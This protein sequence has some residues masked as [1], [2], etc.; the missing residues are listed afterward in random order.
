MTEYRATTRSQAETEALAQSLAGAL[1]PGAFLALYGEL[2]AGKTAFARGVA[3]GLGIQ[4]ITSPTFT[5]VQEYEGCAE[6][7]PLFHF[8]AYRLSG[9]EELDAIGFEE[10]LLRKGI[11]LMEW[12]EHVADALPKA[13]MDVHIAGSGEQ[14]R[15]LLFCAKAEEYIP[16]IGRIKRG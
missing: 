14:P 11:I 9:G 4:G 3:R 12:P 6:K 10:Y 7:L 15:E 2:G 8:D 5:I 16:L 1:F 13:R